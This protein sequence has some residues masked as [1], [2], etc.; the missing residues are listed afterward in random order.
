[1]RVN[2]LLTLQPKKKKKIYSNINTEAGMRCQ[3]FST[4]PDIKETYKIVKQCKTL[5]KLVF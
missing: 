3:V 5:F 2:F 4:K 1:M